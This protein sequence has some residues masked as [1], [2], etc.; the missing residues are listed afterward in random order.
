MAKKILLIDDL[1]GEESESVQTVAWMFN[2]AYY[3][4]ELSEKSVEQFEKALGRFIKASREIRRITAAAKGDATDAEKAR[5][6]AK[7]RGMD[8]GDRG[9]LPAEILDQYKEFV[10]NGGKGE[11]SSD[12]D[13]NSGENSGDTPETPNS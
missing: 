12:S 11:P 7:A 5:Q 4:I 1:S 3:E 6:W 2:G 8:V 9:R 10:K 13:E